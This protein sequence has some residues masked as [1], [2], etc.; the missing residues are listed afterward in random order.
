MDSPGR[1]RF[2]DPGA[3]AFHFDGSNF[4][5]WLRQIALAAG[6]EEIMGDV[7]SVASNGRGGVAQI[8]LTKDSVG[9]GATSLSTVREA[10]QN[11]SQ[12]S[13]RMHA[14]HGA[15]D[16]FVID[17]SPF[18][19]QAE[20]RSRRSR[21]SQ[22]LKR[23][24]RGKCTSRNLSTLSY[25]FASQFANDEVAWQQLRESLLL[26]GIPAVDDLTP[27][28]FPRTVWRR[29]TKFWRDNLLA[30]GTA[31]CQMDPLV[32]SGRHPLPAGN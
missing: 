10:T 4:A 1:L 32:S 21:E 13:R 31:A 20:G 18:G 16:R 22:D 5:G 24:G 15:S 7:A 28:V 29:Q 17:A 19:C 30:L 27:R 3:Y 25:S 14:S 23:D 11:S 26:D 12:P 6:V 9:R 2:L 8:R